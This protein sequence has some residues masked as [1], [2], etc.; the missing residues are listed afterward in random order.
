[1]MGKSVGVEYQA[2][3]HFCKCCNQ[4]VETPKTSAKR[5]FHFSKENCLEWMEE[6][7]WKIEAEDEEGI[8]I[9]AEEFVHET[10]R[11]FATS[12]DD[13]LVVD[14]SEIQK[15]KKLIL[16]EIVA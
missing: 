2:V 14:R 15:V 1:M 12:S 8:F 7:G 4:K 5:V 11:F 6:E 10:I 13:T 3:K 9:M 16:E